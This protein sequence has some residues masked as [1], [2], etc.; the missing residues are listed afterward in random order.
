MT[1]KANKSIIISIIFVLL[2]STMTFS[3]NRVEAVGGVSAQA[4]ILIEQ[5]SGRVLYA[6]DEH[7]QLRIA[8]I[9]KIMTAILAIESGMLEE[10]VTV[11]NNASGT[12]GSSLYLKPG[13]KIKL[14]D[15]VY[16]LM[17]RSGNDSAVAIAEHV[18][19]S[20]DGFIYM[21]NEKAREI[22]MTRTVFNNPHGLDDH[23]EHYSTAYDMALLTKYAMENETYREVSSTKSY[24]APQE[25]EKWDR[26]WQNKNRLLTQLY[27]YSTGGKTG[28]TKRANRTLVST[29]T[30][31]DLDLIAV[32]LN[33]PSDW[34]DH[35]NM[36]NWAFEAYELKLLVKEGFVKGIEE[37][38][39]KDQVYAPYTFTYP[40]TKDEQKGMKK[41]VT[42]YRPPANNKWEDGDITEPVGKIMLTIKD[43][44]IGEIPLY[45]EAPEIE[46][47]QSFWSKVKE[48]FFIT[49]GVNPYD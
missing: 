39:Y 28:Y 34:H 42:L 2:F 12:E 49:I 13:E 30:K 43:D 40:L 32:T 3:G 7:A 41:K 44:K 9:T 25:G 48:M 20:L 45:Y 27:K 36:F 26:I 19:G 11:S 6:K 23:E 17:L 15:L 22:G 35:M 4:A 29:A 8:S 24:R 31:D 18:G 38:F 21:M 10:T 47:K 46:E 16:G 33:A 14:K 5:S 1:K 37:E